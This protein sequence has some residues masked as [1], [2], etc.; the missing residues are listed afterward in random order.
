MITCRQ[1]GHPNEAGQTFC[2]NPDCGSTLDGAP[3][4]RATVAPPYAEVAVGKTV[5]ITLRLANTGTGVEELALGIQGRLG[6]CAAITPAR[7]RLF[8]GDEGT[9]IVRFEPTAGPDLPIGPM[10]YAITV[11]S[12]STAD[13][14]TLAFG[15]LTIVDTS[16]S[17]LTVEPTEAFGRFDATYRLEV[18]N[19]TSSVIEGQ[20]VA[21]DTEQQLRFD[22]TPYALR[23][24]PGTSRTGWLRVRPRRSHWVGRPRRYG[25]RVVF[26]PRGDD[27]L[28]AEAVMV[29]R[30]MFL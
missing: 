17:R 30:P 8:P 2:A 3:T 7:L 25:F 23:L 4:I 27:A 14:A 12:W 20:L 1:C 15:V 9:A 11:T 6:A 16:E 29:H 22:V 21:S 19:S 18:R 13:I 26:Q 10:P 5:D 28:S 24:E